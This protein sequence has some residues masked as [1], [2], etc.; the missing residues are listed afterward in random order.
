[1]MEMM[2]NY[3]NNMAELFSLVFVFLLIYETSIFHGVFMRS[4]VGQTSQ[5]LC[6]Y[7]GFVLVKYL[8]RYGANCAIGASSHEYQK[9]D[10]NSEDKH[11]VLGAP[12]PI[13]WR[14]RP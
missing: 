1:M 3:P 13:L 12:Y 10:R 8:G 4:G 2:G 5:V 11:I 7:P 9:T 14:L 6:I